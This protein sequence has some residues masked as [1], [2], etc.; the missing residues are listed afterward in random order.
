MNA[1]ANT[2]N[3]QRGIGTGVVFTAR[4]VTDTVA[5]ATAM[6]V[7]PCVSVSAPVGMVLM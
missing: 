4:C 6:F 7:T 1:A 2:I 3:I 5:V